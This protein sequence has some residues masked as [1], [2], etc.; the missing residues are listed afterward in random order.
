[1]DFYIW[2]HNL[3]QLKETLGWLKTEEYLQVLERIGYT[4]IGYLGQTFV[5]KRK[6]YKLCFTNE[7]NFGK[8]Q[9]LFGTQKDV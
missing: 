1:M 8:I 5:M 6:N 4:K 9:N 2:S 3:G 7:M